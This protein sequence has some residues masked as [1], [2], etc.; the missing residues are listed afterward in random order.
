LKG[1]GENMKRLL[2]IVALLSVSLMIFGTSLDEEFYNYRASQDATGMLNFINQVKSIPTLTKS[3]TLLTL[4]ADACTEYG[5][6]GAPND[7]K[8]SYYDDALN[9]AKAA[10]KI[11]PD[12]AYLNFVAGAAIGRL[13][14]YKGIIQSLFM[15]GD[16]DNY[17][18][19]AIK[20]DPKIYR[21]YVA[22][23]MRYRDTPWPFSN[24]DKS[25]TLFKEALS[26]DPGYVYGYYE[27][28][29][30]YVDWGKKDLANETFQKIV[31]MPVEPEFAAQETQC[32]IDAQKYLDKN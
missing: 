16:F 27:L 7:K 5:L 1:G 30:L 24:F 19:K 8:A 31:S 17:I 25:E 4:L 11:T 9:Y 13:A 6:W 2:L 14:Q 26:I 21:A 12:N 10:L 32:K 22:L 18:N 29:M 23:A 20:L 3:A 15:L 28:A